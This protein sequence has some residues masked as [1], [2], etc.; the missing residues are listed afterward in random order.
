M[1]NT[2]LIKEAKYY[3]DRL[4]NNNNMKKNYLN[5]LKNEN[6]E[7][8]ILYTFNVQHLKIIVKRPKSLIYLKLVAGLSKDKAIGRLIV[9]PIRVNQNK[10]INHLNNFTINHLHLDFKY[11][12]Y[13]HFLCKPHLTILANILKFMNIKKLTLTL[14]VDAAVRYFFEYRIYSDILIYYLHKYCKDTCITINYGEDD[15]HF[16]MEF[17]GCYRIA[18]R[19]YY[20]S[21]FWTEN[22]IFNS[23]CTIIDRTKTNHRSFKLKHRVIKHIK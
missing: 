12:K 17:W 6:K 21:Y 9:D 1:E 16:K 19:Y 3:V 5:L 18:D 22:G 7:N 15:L 8:K 20:N 13:F 23:N 14:D 4:K 11:F 10:I 2:K